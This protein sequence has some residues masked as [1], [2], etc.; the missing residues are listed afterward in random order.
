MAKLI[1]LLIIEF[2]EGLFDFLGNEMLNGIVPLALHAEDYMS[3]L[4]ISGFDTLF[5]IFLDFG[6]SLI[7]LKFLKKGFEIYV[8]WTDGDADADADPVQLLTNFFRAMAIALTFPILY[9]W[10]AEI[11][12]DMSDKALNAIGLSSN[13]NFTTLINTLSTAGIFSVISFLVF[14]IIFI[15]LYTIHQERFRNIN[16]KNRSTSSMCR[17]YGC[18]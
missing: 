5:N 4:G 14:F 17:A 11:V 10:L 12:A 16:I 1:T 8:L 15:L 13:A 9:G 2:L 18:R 6:I 3:G 7:I